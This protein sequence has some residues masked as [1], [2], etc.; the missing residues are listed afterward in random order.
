[1][2]HNPGGGGSSKAHTQKNEHGWRLKKSPEPR[3]NPLT[4][5][6]TGLFN[7]DSYNGL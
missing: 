6:Y 5:H 4:F 2:V 7:R 1:M 3:K